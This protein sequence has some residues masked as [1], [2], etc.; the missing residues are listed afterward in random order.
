MNDISDLASLNFE[1]LAQADLFDLV[2][3]SSK[4]EAGL[5]E[6]DEEMRS[7]SCSPAWPGQ[8][9]RYTSITLIN[10]EQICLRDTETRAHTPPAEWG[11]SCAPDTMDLNSILCGGVVERVTSTVAPAMELPGMAGVGGAGEVSST[12]PSSSLPLPPGSIKT[13]LAS[14]L[15]LPVPARLRPSLRSPAPRLVISSSSLEAAATNNNSL[16]RSALTSKQGAGGV[17]VLEPERDT[18]PRTLLATVKTESERQT[19]EDILLLQLEGREAVARLKHGDTRINNQLF[20]NT[21]VTRG[22]APAPD[23]VKSPAPAPKLPS[24]PSSSVISIEVDVA[25][26][27]V[28]HKTGDPPSPAPAPAPATK[29]AHLAKVSRKYHRRSKEEPKK[30]SRLLHYCHIC[31]KGFK[32][33]YSVNVHV[34]THTGEKPFSCQLCGKC[35]RQKAHLAKHQQTHASKQGADS[36]P[37]SNILQISSNEA[38]S[39]RF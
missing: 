14:Q 33:K 36:Q 13:I 29:L 30:E 22:P 28:L 39:H 10:G 31:N 24:A 2:T 11:D 32:D 5:E 1:D 15:P 17:V 27:L 4:E 9:Q 34:R 35:F 38:E 7:R 25:G 19:A 23:T 8:E 3:S 6:E 26:N 12:V 16:L 20:P 21:R 37:S 18:E